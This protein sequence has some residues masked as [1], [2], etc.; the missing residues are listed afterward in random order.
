RFMALLRPRK[1]ADL[2]PQSGPKRT[3]IRSMS[4]I[5]FR[6]AVTTRAI[7]HRPSRTSPG[8]LEKNRD[9]PFSDFCTKKITRFVATAFILQFGLIQ[10]LRRLSVCSEC[11][12]QRQ[13]AVV[14]DPIDG[15]RDGPDSNDDNSGARCPLRSRSNRSAN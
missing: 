9:R 8:P 4:A 3:L 11:V 12:A 10:P 15:R 13:V 7:D 1:M 6:P 14:I 5:F 2:S